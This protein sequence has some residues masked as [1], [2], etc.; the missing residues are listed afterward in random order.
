MHERNE[1]SR[2]GESNDFNAVSIYSQC[3]RNEIISR[4]FSREI[5]RSLKQFPQVDSNA[6]EKREI[7]RSQQWMR[8]DPREARKKSK[9]RECNEKNRL[10]IRRVEK[11][12]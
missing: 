1:S 11:A 8:L 9:K 3:R 6:L 4:V 10:A 2:Y 12:N 5:R 7:E